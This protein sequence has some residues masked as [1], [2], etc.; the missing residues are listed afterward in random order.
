[1]QIG[2]RGVP[3]SVREAWAADE[4]KSERLVSAVVDLRINV[5]NVR[6]RLI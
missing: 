2:V 3:P 4:Q 1:L 5:F 6:L